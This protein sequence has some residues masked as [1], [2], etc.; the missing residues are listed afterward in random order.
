MASEPHQDTLLTALR[1]CSLAV[2][3]RLPMTTALS[4]IVTAGLEGVRAGTADLAAIRGRRDGSAS[5][6]EL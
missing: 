3:S 1:I 4:R 5:H 2:T 6:S